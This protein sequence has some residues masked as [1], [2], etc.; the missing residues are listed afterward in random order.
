MILASINILILSLLVLI[1]GLIKPKWLLFWM[2]NPGRMPIIWIASI[3]FMTA[4][5]LFGEGHRQNETLT[6]QPQPT[7]KAQSDPPPIDVKEKQ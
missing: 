7:I 1:V 3:L 2:D 5:V 4:V 6:G